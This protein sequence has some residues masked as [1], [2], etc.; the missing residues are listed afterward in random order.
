MREKDKK[1]K[2]YK[3]SKN[4]KA[5]IKKSR[6]EVH[7]DYSNDQE[8]A[9]NYA[10]ESISEKTKS[11]AYTAGRKAEQYGRHSLKAA[12]DTLRKARSGVA[13]FKR[14]VQTAKTP[15][16]TAQAAVK[17]SKRAAQAARAAAKASTRAAKAVAETIKAAAGA[18][19]SIVTL[20]AAGG[21]I[22]I[23]VILII[24]MAGF[25]LSSGFG[26]FYSDNKTVSTVIEKV[27]NEFLSEIERIKREN[28]HDEVNDVQLPQNWKEVLA[29]YSVRHSL[30]I[31]NIDNIEYESVKTIFWDINTVTF[32]FEALKQDSTPKT[33]LNI[34]VKNKGCD[35]IAEQYAFNSEQRKQLDE[36]LKPGYNELWDALLSR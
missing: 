8:T 9:C 27:N 25:I 15:A 4:M 35:E 5:V 28:P 32:S 10:T 16:R 31:S 1:I 17:S 6:D 13:G 26:I 14:K 19:K 11:I 12:P 18:V 22:A 20:V 3:T 34:T 21:W 36:L 24:C 7:H 2:L 29:V 23:A 30:D 33:I